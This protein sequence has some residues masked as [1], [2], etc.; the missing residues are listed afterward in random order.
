LGGLLAWEMAR[1]LTGKS[2]S[3]G[4]LFLIDTYPSAAPSSADDGVSTLT[5]LDWFAQD[6]A[7]L[8]GENSEG[9]DTALQQLTREE[10]WTSVQQL[11]RRHGLVS[12]RNASEDSA[13][14]LEVFTRNV[15]A[16]ES[17]RLCQNDQS[18]VLLAATESEAPEG[19]ATQWKQWATDVDLHL[20]PGN[21]YSI[22][23]RP[24]VGAVA[25]VLNDARN[26]YLNY[27]A[28]S[29]AVVDAQR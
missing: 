9:G 23:R 6:I 15:Q 12:Q 7:R 28:S 29:S 19:L 26:Q 17:Y 20:V 5:M 8:V 21:H 1:Q 4:R 10:R 2:E 18:V 25:K 22:M 24:N 14:L 16:M 13:A 27:G 11:L 3:V